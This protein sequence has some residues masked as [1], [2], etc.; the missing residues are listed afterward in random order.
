MR[1]ERSVAAQLEPE[2]ALRQ[3]L[4]VDMAVQHV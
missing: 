4:V 1:K 3:K 2:L